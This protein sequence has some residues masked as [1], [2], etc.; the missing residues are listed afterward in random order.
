MSERLLILAEKPSA[1]QHFKEALGGMSGVFEG[2]QYEIAA[3]RGHLLTL[4][5]PN[6]M[7]IRNK[8]KYE[9]WK[10]L[11]LFPWEASDLS[12]EKTYNTGS[13]S[14]KDVKA[15]LSKI[16]QAA[17]GKDAIVIATDNDPTGEGDGLGWEIVNWMKWKKKVYRIRFADESAKNLKQ[18]L[19][20]KTDVTDQM[21]QGEY[22][23]FLARE[24]FDLM[25]MQL[26]RIATIVARNNNFDPDRLGFGRLKST[27]IDLVYE[28]TKKRDEYVKKPFFEVR[29]KD[30]NGNVFS[31]KEA[32]KFESRQEAENAISKA[33]GSRE[34]NILESTEKRQGAP[35]LPDLGR[36]SVLMSKKGFK[37]KD[38]ISTYQ[39]MYEDRV[40]SYPR[41]EDKK[42]TPEQFEELRPL[43]GK[44]AK[45]VGIDPGLLEL[46][47]MPNRFLVPAAAHGANR[48]GPNVPESLSEVRKKYGEAGKFIY[49]IVSRAFLASLA[50]D[51][52]YDQVKAGLMGT[53]YTATIKVIKKPGYQA[54]FSDLDK[55]EKTA[56]AFG[57]T[58][59][60]FAFEGSNSKP[61]A[62]DQEF[63]I[64]FLEKNSIGTGATRVSTL[65]NIST[66]KKSRKNGKTRTLDPLVKI[67]KKS[68]ALTY[69]GE[70]QA[71]LGKGTEI[72]SAETTKQL[73]SDMQA[74]KEG[75]L[76][77]QE[78]S[79]KITTIVMNDLPIIA[80]NGEKLA[81]DK[82]LMELAKKKKPAFGRRKN[83][84]EEK[85]K[86]EGTFNGEEVSFN[87]VWS[88]HRFT[89]AEVE[90]LLAGE[91]IVIEA[92]GKSGK[93]FKC[94]GKLEKQEY[95]GHEFYGFNNLGFV[96]GDDKEYAEGKWKGED[97]RFNRTWA[98]HR[99]S[100]K[101]VEELLDGQTIV[102][103][104]IGKSG[105][106]FTAQVMLE[107][108]EYNGRSFV[109]AKLVDFV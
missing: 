47:E 8:E 107:R 83:M 65:A 32:K 22:L 31:K 88:Q 6:D 7:A 81:S 99:F 75:K 18:A 44:I 5:H 53:D 4:P 95:N 69:E 15:T 42:V 101:E 30:E 2:D 93:E 33:P 80:K 103:D 79:G 92:K 16:K 60:P 55:D 56:K 46:A 34:V 39:K 23:E 50:G 105:K 13:G 14:L 108:Q 84:F 3:S 76:N 29:F 11:R 59:S 38:V 87:R 26:S 21:A 67:E 89:D 94:K 62:P 109:G 9:N 49:S 82:R 41:T 63:V 90:R 96:D 10:D 74:V 71:I 98:K 77:W 57:K 12:W 19:R 100:D 37:P 17:V 27:I 40:V 68:F 1:A 106:N 20:E 48:P 51:C 25:S 91:T 70:V 52:V 66:P 45:C 78:A 28:Q 104:G 73:L 54:I 97:I 85:E 61:K 35:L 24:R 102:V 58:A 72:A 36:L 43:A 86:A 64:K